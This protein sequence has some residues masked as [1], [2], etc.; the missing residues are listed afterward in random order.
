MATL[1]RTLPPGLPAGDTG[2]VSEP[3]FRSDLYRGTARYYDQDRVPYPQALIQDLAG[4]AEADGSGRLLD[5]ACG[6]GQLIFALRRHFAEAWAVD[7]EPEMAGLVRE[8]AARAGIHGIRPV[9]SAAETAD[10][11][12]ELQAA[13]PGGRFR[14]TLTF[15]YDLA[16]RPP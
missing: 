11:G 4:R 8:K 14:Q 16:R 6:T 15:A 2:G 1:S 3:E 7:Q 12:R 5:L 9:V 13:E 10:L